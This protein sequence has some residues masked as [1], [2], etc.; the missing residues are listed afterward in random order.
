[1]II[2]LNL[3]PTTHSTKDNIIL[4]K[5]LKRQIDAISLFIIL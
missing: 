1:M 5:D 4:L 2:E 3:T